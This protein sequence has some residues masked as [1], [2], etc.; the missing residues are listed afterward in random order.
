M[1]NDEDFSRMEMEETED[2]SSEHIE[3]VIECGDIVRPSNEQSSSD[4]E[5]QQSTSNFSD[6]GMRAVVD[7]SLYA[8]QAHAQD[9]F[10]IAVV[11]ER[12]LASGGEDDVAFLWDQHV[13]DSD[14]VLKIEHDDSVTHVAFNN[15][16]TLLATADMSGKITIVQLSD[17]STR[18]KVIC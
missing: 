8:L 4:D 16:Q 18:A 1:P 3:R 13:S 2:L 9:C 7:D 12:W 15:S 5:D 17:L 14:P 11:A 6:T 10:A